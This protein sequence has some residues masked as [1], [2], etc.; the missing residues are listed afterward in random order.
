M[1]I[2]RFVEIRLNRMKYVAGYRDIC[3]PS[4]HVTF[5]ESHHD[6]DLSPILT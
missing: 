1:K 6:N 3:S 4:S 2:G 5:A